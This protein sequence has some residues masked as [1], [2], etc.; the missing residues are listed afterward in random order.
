MCRTGLKFLINLLKCLPIGDFEK[1]RKSR[2][3]PKIRQKGA[4]VDALSARKVEIGRN[5]AELSFMRGIIGTSEG[6]RD[7]SH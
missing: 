1:L 4:D 6:M 7:L 3:T 5:L 2:N